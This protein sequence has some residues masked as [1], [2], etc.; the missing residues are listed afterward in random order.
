MIIIGGGPGGLSTALHL[1]KYHPEIA[2]RTLVIEKARYPRVKLC[3]GGLVVDAEVILARLGLDTSEVPHV[4]AS[5]IH[6]DFEGK[7]LGLRVP[8]RHALRIIRRDEFDDWLARNVQARGVEILQG[9][10]VRDIRPD[11]KGVTVVTEA[12][13]FR[14]Q[15][16]VGADGSNGITRRCVFPQDPVS[17]ARLLEIITPE[18]AP[19]SRAARHAGSAAY[20]DFF[21]VPEGIAGYTWDFPTQIHGERRRCWGVYDTNLLAHLPRPALKEPLAAEMKRQ[22]FELGDYEIKGHPIR[23]FE[24]QGPLA[25]PR[26]LLVGD[27]AGSDPLFGEGISIALGYGALAAAEI[28]ESFRRG[29][30]SFQGYPQRVRDSSLGRSLFTRWFIAKVIYRM[31]WRWFQVLLWRVMKLAVLAGGWLLVV[32]WGRRLR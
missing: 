12:G 27:A 10:A 5:E 32:N 29:D 19:A 23:W 30:F 3:A 4:D 21:P 17:T 11:A 25:A 9:A 13:V 15:V 24:P 16:V 31:R 7:G 8:N 28:G 20:F 1:A 18:P 6:L 14:A 2:R 22:G 26:V